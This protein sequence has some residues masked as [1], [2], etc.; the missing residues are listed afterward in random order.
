MF[1]GKLMS[2]T[3]VGRWAG[4]MPMWSKKFEKY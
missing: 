4:E 3:G 2:D 1:Y